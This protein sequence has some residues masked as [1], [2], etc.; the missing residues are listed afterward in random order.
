MLR[1][2]VENNRGNYIKDWDV[3]E[4]TGFISAPLSI[5]F[6]QPQNGILK[7]YNKIVQFKISSLL[8]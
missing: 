1:A 8:L 5:Y 2:H 3:A 7:F 4:T 6:T